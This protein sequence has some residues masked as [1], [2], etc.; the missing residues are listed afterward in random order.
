MSPFITDPAG[1]AGPH[2]AGGPIGPYG[3]L[4]PFNSDPA[5]PVGPYVA[6]GPVGPFGTLSPSDSGSAILLDPGGGTL[7]PGEGGPKSCPS[8]LTD[9]LVL[10]AAVTLP[11]VQDPM[12]TQ[13]PVEVIVGDRGVV[14]EENIT[15]HDG[16]SDPDVVGTPAVVAMVGMNALPIS[17]DTP[18]DCVDECTEWN[19]RDQ[20]E[21]ID[22]MVVYYG[23]D[24]CYSDESDW[25]DL[26]DVASAEYVEQYNFDILEGMELMVHERCRGP[27]GSE[28][29]ENEETGLTHVCQTTLSYP[30]D[31]LDTVDVDTLA[32]VDT[33]ADGR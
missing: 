32:E 7:L 23:G 9:N 26:Y 13:S 28:M 25:D 19:I 18:L 30:R 24:L 21:T 12:V 16:W 15:V 33:L 27:Y 22:G 20:F 6:G 14:T 17:N 11:A 31:E 3:T 4:S 29:R 8:V 5:G 1:P 10:V 2:D